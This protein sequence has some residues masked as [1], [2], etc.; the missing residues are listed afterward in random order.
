MYRPIVCRL[1]GGERVKS[2]TEHH[3]SDTLC[4]RKTFA[5]NLEYP[6]VPLLSCF[7]GASGIFALAYH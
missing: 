4:T 5:K 1:S 3:P 6:E 7:S 2:I